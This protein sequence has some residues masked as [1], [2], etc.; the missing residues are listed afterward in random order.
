MLFNMGMGLCCRADDPHPTSFIL[1]AYILINVIFT[2][3][4]FPVLVPPT[5]IL[6]LGQGWL[7]WCLQDHP[8]APKATANAWLPFLCQRNPDHLPFITA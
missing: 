3:L 8:H 7:C 2:A 6:M 5:P 1:F 4:A